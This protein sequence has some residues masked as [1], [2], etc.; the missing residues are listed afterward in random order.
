MILTTG[1]QD[2]VSFTDD[3]SLPNVGAKV[4]IHAQVIR[5]LPLDWYYALLQRMPSHVGELKSTMII[6]V[7]FALPDFERRRVL[8]TLKTVRIHITVSFR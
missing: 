4:S 3:T 8:S 5:E 6:E 7:F 1:S 2:A